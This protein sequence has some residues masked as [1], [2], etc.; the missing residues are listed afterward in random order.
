MEASHVVTGTKVPTQPIH[1]IIKHQNS[2][3]FWG[4]DGCWLPCASW[5]IAKAHAYD[6]V[7]YDGTFGTGLHE[8]LFEHNNLRMICDLVA[9]WTNQGLIT[10]ETQV[11]INHIS[12]LSNLPHSEL[13]TYFAPH[14]VKV[15]YDGLSVALPC[16]AEQSKRTV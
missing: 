8:Y 14:G 12:K 13:V 10:P 3:M 2:T 15:A 1:Y 4:C 9:V 7:V 5:H 6:M 11:Y 16:G